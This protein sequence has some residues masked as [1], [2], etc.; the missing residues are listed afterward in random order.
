MNYSLSRNNMMGADEVYESIK[1]RIL[2]LELEPGKKISE[3]QMCQE[4]NLSRSVIRIVFTRLSEVNLVDIA[5]QRGTYVSLFELR[6]IEDLQILRTAVE[7][8]VL[9]HMF[10]KLSKEEILEVVNKLKEN[11]NEQRKYINYSNYDSGFEKLDYDFHSILCN[12]VKLTGIMGLIS[13]SMIHL[14]RWRNF[15]VA[16]DNRIPELIGEHAKM[17]EAIEE[18]SLI[19]SQE[20]ITNHLETV[21]AMDKRAKAKYP[22]YFK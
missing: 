12:S 16:F 19:K 21:S 5:P 6:H 4:Y 8:E 20:A 14:E 18:G 7:K 11:L 17:I 15:N 3:N 13:N 9:F 10:A 2:K 22:Q 1:N